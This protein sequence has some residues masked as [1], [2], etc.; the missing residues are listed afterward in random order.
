MEGHL[1]GQATEDTLMS[2]WRLVTLT[3]LGLGLLALEPI[4]AAE[5]TEFPPE[6]RARFNKGQELR[7]QQRYQEA[8]EAFDEAIKLGMAKY[9]RVHLYRADA[10]LKLKEFDSAITRYT[11]FIDHFGIEE[12]CRY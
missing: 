10:L 11:E 12:S 1:I 2:S 7:A 6:A 4:W 5:P 8:I 9:P 3:W